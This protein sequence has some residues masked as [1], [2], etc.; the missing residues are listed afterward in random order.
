MAPKVSHKRPLKRR[1]AD[2]WGIE[3][4]DFI[5]HNPDWDRRNTGDVKNLVQFLIKS[6]VS[7]L[8]LRSED[9]VAFLNILEKV[10]ASRTY[11]PVPM[12]VVLNTIFLGC[13]Q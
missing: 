6:S 10:S 8:A 5:K 11:K 13:A 3:A 7:L 1:E 2:C 12:Q 9:A 4:Q